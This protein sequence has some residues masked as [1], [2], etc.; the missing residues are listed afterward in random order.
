MR[1]LMHP[2]KEVVGYCVECG[3]FGCDECIFEF[4]NQQYCKKHYAPLERRARD[5]AKKE[6]QRLVVHVEDGR[7]LHGTS[8]ALNPQNDSFIFNPMDKNGGVAEKAIKIDFEQLKAVFYVRSYDGKFDRKSVANEF[9]QEGRPIVVEFNDGEILT[10]FTHNMDFQTKPRFTMIPED[11]LSNNVS[12]LVERKATL[13]VF[14]PE[15]FLKREQEA[16]DAYVAEYEGV[17]V[18]RE[19]L[20][21]DY[22]FKRHEFI[23]AAKVYEDLY[24]QDPENLGIRSKLNSAQYNIAINFIRKHQV[25][26]AIHMLEAILALDPKHEKGKRKLEQIHQKIRDLEEA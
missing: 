23:K 8:M 21:G 15:E 4:E 18:S 13:G 6:R 20:T 16:I 17:S 24:K 2:L 11:P 26:R 12:V 5:K 25:A 9:R 19:E 3:A 22:F 1:C 14:S 7:I 10:G